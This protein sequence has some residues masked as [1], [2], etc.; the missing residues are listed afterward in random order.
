MTASSK[1]EWVT[2]RNPGAILVIDRAAAASPDPGQTKVSLTLAA[3][4][5][6][7]ED[8]SPKTLLDISP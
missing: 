3:A 7:I 2:A 5:G 8:A 4:A 1:S 6:Y